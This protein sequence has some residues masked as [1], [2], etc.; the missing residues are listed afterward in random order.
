MKAIGKCPKCGKML[1]T[2]DSYEINDKEIF[3]LCKGDYK[4][5]KMKLTLA[6]E[7]EKELWKIEGREDKLNIKNK[8]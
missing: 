4:S 7:D 2:N 3:H 6:P 1:E 5:I 8:K